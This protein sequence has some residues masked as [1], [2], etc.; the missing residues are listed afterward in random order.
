[1]FKQLKSD[2]KI[3]KKLFI[4][5]VFSISL[6]L[7]LNEFLLT[8]L[9]SEDGVLASSSRF[10]IWLF[11]GFCVGLGLLLVLSEK[12]RGFFGSIYLVIIRKKTI[13]DVIIIIAFSF[14]GFICF[15]GG[16]IF[17]RSLFHDNFA[18]F[19]VIRDQWHSLN[20]FGEIAWWFPQNQFGS[21]I[22]VS[23]FLGISMISFSIFGFFIWLFGVLGI[24]ISTYYLIYVIFFAFFQPFLVTLGVYFLAR[25]IFNDRLVIYFCII[26]SS[27]SPGVMLNISDFGCMD[28]AAF[29]LYFFAAVIYLV[30]KPGNFSFIVLCFTTSLLFLSFNFSFLFWNVV[31][32]PTFLVVSL[33]LSKNNFNSIKHSLLS[34]P[35]YYWLIFVSVLVITFMPT[36]IAYFQ[37]GDLVR[38][39]TGQTTYNFTHI[40]S[41]NPLE[42]LTVSLPG[43]AFEWTKEGHPLIYL[44]QL[45]PHN[46]DVQEF[47]HLS[48]NYMGMLCL[49]LAI[50][51]LIY[52]QT[53]KR[54][55]FY[56]LT[57]I[58]GIACLSS[59]S[60]IM[61]IFIILFKPLQ[62][63][64]HFSDLIFRAGGYLVVLFASAE[65]LGVILEGNKRALKLLITVFIVLSLVYI[66]IHIAVL[67]DVVMGSNYFGLMVFLV[68]FYVI[69][70][71]WLKDCKSNLEYR[72][73]IISLLLLMF[74]DIST[75]TYLHVRSLVFNQKAA[76]ISENINETVPDNSLGTINFNSH[77][78]INANTMI[79]HNQFLNMKKLSF[80]FNILEK[81]KLF[82]SAH[83]NN[84]ISD[85]LKN[86]T[87]NG[88]ENYKSISLSS[89]DILESHQF[90]KFHNQN[91]LSGSSVKGSINL[92]YQTYNRFE[93]NVFSDQDAL[94]FIRDGYS[95]YWKASVNGKK[96]EI[97][98][99]LY[100]FKAIPV[101]KGN[102]EI[103]LK[104]SPP[105]V[106]ESLALAFFIVIILGIILI[107]LLSK[108]YKIV[109]SFYHK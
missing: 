101:F 25:Q 85:E 63:N 75:Y 96:V 44:W 60:P 5:G 40:Q 22:Y 34:F 51:G 28:S 14:F 24:D 2:S 39:K 53:I 20:H 58:F 80:D 31:A 1:M 103:I 36:I 99:A 7:I 79:M 65:G 21:A 8:A 42:M 105:L 73:I 27:F 33:L 26:M 81:F 30:R 68:M 52:G 18:A 41:G 46:L 43:F 48:I 19:S 17:T 70:L 66:V 3:E 29:S 37:I 23:T 56:F 67:K 83:F 11:D 108:K 107:I 50:I 76:Y 38:S 54:H 93:I 62:S 71:I 9:F 106:R 61:S 6:G 64:N 4:F 49:P 32:I 78:H 109:N 82:N 92:I 86:I 45:I 13:K 89:K 69:L 15:G 35:Y 74:L 97:A 90:S 95:P 59:Y 55:L 16:F 98:R 102:S 47:V 100:N 72:P 84:D 12:F 94:L 10:K 87:D 77:P 104:F 88:F 91:Y 57:I